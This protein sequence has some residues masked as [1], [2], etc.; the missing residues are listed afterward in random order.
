MTLHVETGTDVFYLI[1]ISK[2]WESFSV[3]REENCDF[4]FLGLDIQSEK[5]HIAI[6]QNN[7]IEQLKKEDINPVCKFQ[8]NNLKGHIK[9]KNWST[10]SDIKSHS[11]RY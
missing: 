2:L 10:I 9:S 7:H 3:G 6:D 11:T 8:K 4:W 5:F 1:I